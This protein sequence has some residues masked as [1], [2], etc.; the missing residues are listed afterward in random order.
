MLKDPDGR[1]QT[2]EGRGPFEVW[3]GLQNLGIYVS[4]AKRR[5]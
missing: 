5:V 2:V 1:G 3:G 4:D